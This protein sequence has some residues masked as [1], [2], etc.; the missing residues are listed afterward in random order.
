[1]GAANDRAASGQIVLSPEAWALV[2]DRCEGT[3]GDEGYVQLA[4]VNAPSTG[5]ALAR[6]TPT[7]EAAAALRAFIP[8]AIRNRL[9]AG[10]SDWLAELRRVTVI[11]VNLP[12]LDHRTPLDK[13][14]EVIRAL[15]TS[16]YRYEGSINKIS[17]DDKGASLIA[18]LG[19][20]PLAHEDDPARG[21]RAGLSMQETL[22]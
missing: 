18:V 8:A 1:V 16:L 4:S 21:T 22:T 14:Q 10:Q 3:A 12:D 9:D 6:S 11:F 7:S 5:A 20:P 17:V 2:A 15:Q 19:L 13:G